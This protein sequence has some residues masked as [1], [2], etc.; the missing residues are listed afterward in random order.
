MGR[1]EVYY[2]EAWGAVCGENWDMVDANVVCKML[3]YGGASAHLQNISLEQENDT[4]W[5]SGV[6]CT[7]NESSLTQCAHTG[8]GKH[9]CNITQAAGVTC[10]ERHWGEYVSLSIYERKSSSLFILPCG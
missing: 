2:S 6:H 10:F 8:W 9:T 5:L 7:G 1:V 4:E 3:G